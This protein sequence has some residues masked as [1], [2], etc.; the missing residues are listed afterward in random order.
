MLKIV[1]ASAVRTISSLA[2]MVAKQK[3]ATRVEKALLSFLKVTR[4][5]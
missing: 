4:A 3:N 1:F 2:S 5:Q